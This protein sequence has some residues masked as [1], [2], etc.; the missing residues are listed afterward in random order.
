M[1]TL[2]ADLEAANTKAQRFEAALNG[3]LE[4]QRK[5]VPDHLQALLDKL[6]PV[7]QLEWLAGNTDKLNSN[8]GIP[9]TPKGQ[10]GMTEAQKQEA[11]KSAQRFTRSRF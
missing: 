10:N 5:A 9:S 1:G 8:S 4:K 7:E 3:L 11:S 6:D 2:T